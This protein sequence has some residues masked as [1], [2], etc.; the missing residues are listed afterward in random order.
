MKL[1]STQVRCLSNNQMER[2]GCEHKDKDEQ[3][4]VDFHQ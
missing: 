3:M 1:K 2:V 4:N